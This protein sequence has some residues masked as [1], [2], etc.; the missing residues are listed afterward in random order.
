LAALRRI[1]TTLHLFVIGGLYIFP[2]YESGKGA[3][4]FTARLGWK[5]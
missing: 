5:H 3:D 1:V 4:R 2:A